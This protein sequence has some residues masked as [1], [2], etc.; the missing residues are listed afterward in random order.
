MTSRTKSWVEQHEAGLISGI[1]LIATLLIYY[2]SSR[3]KLNEVAETAKATAEKVNKVEIE[4]AKIHGWVNAQ[5]INSTPNPKT[6]LAK[7]P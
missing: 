7:I 5:Q 1:T 3:E 2:G 6:K 4:V